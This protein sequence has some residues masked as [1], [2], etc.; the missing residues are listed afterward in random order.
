MDISEKT[1]V[2]LFACAFVLPPL[3]GGIAW[4]TSI[5]SIATAAE[6]KA[7]ENSVQI[8]RQYDLLL[9]IRERLATLEGMLKRNRNKE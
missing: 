4:L 7:R 8:E 3:I 6:T 2:P 5:Y 1:K 9:E